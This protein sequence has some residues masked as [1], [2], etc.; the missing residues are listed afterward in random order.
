MTTFHLGTLLTVL[1]GYDLAPGGLPAVR[2]LLEH[3]TGRRPLDLGVIEAY[4]QTR[5]ELRAQFPALAELYKPRFAHPDDTAV[6]LAAQ[7]A[8]FGEQHEVTPIRTAD[9]ALTAT[10]KE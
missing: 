7:V 2:E 9:L 10:S 3:T 5:V 6:W 1:T 8:R 4:V